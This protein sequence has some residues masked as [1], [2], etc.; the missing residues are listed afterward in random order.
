[1][2]EIEIKLRAPNLEETILK[3]EKLGCVISQPKTQKDIN[4]VHKDDVR[5]FELGGDW[6]Y[7][8]LRIEKDKPLLLT[9]K[10]PMKNAMDRMEYEMNISSEKDLRG[11]M[12]LFGYIEG[13]TVEKT[14]RTCDYKDYHIT[15]DQ[16]TKLGDFVEIERMIEEG[17][18][19]KIQAEMFDFGQNVL[20][21]KKDET[22]MK[23][24]DILMYYFLNK[25]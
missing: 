2:R 15:L 13:V 9:V 6:S 18:A 21:L 3:L 4:F 19:E 20:G 1:M 7:P 14:R 10:K 11:M 17:D 16:V 24:Y 23:G 5:W 22:I 8:R 12:E 25:K